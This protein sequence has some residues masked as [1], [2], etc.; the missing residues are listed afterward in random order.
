MYEEMQIMM[1]YRPLWG[2]FAFLIDDHQINAQFLFLEERCPNR[3]YIKC[4]QSPNLNWL[5]DCH[6][7]S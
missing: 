4:E 2:M 6:R 1:V 3:H 7:P 5:G